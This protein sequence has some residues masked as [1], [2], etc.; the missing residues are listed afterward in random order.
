MKQLAA[1]I[2]DVDGTIIDTSDFIIDAYKYTL[3]HHNL[4][5][6]TRRSL[7]R[8]ITRSRKKTYSW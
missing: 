5:E 7:S 6:R 2:F 8:F 1:V 4:P 3:A